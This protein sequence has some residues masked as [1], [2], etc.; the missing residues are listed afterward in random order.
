MGNMG[1]KTVNLSA[2]MSIIMLNVHNSSLSVSA[3][4]YIVNYRDH[5]F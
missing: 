5:C 3:Q 1:K 2:T 4:L